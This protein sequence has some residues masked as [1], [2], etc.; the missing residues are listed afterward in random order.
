M[1]G[2]A[3]VRSGGGAAARSGSAAV[4]RSGSAAVARS[5]S[6]AAARSD[7][8]AARSGGAAA[9]VTDMNPPA[10]LS[11]CSLTITEGCCIAA[12]LKGWKSWCSA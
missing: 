5:G 11:V 4:A 3:A 1:S 2:G 10:G 8:A 12:G 9:D 7:G 6:G